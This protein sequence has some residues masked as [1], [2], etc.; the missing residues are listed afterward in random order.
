MTNYYSYIQTDDTYLDNAKHAT[1]KGIAI[2]T[3]ILLALT[4]IVGVLTARFLPYLSENKEELFIAGLFVASI[5]SFFSVIIGRLSFR[6]A[7]VCSIIYAVSEGL[8]LGTITALFNFYFEHAG[9]LAITATVVIFAVMLLLYSFG[10][11]RNFSVTRMVIWGLL[12]SFF[13]LIILDFIYILLT[14][15][16]NVLLYLLIQGILLVYGVISLSLNF[17]EA[18]AVTK[19]GAP[20]N[21]EWSVAL[22]MEVSLVFIYIQV[23]K[24]ILILFD[25][26]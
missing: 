22:G 24:I 13:A 14:G 17:A 10:F 11:T 7:K 23:L 12:F 2:K 19:A 25:R 18:E 15:S 26:R 9:T 21:A 3:S 4:I 20:K 16:N 5:A 6:A 1:Y 8:L